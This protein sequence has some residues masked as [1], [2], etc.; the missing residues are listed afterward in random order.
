MT[1]GPGGFSILDLSRGD[2]NV[3]KLGGHWQPDSVTIQCTVSHTCF[4]L[5]PGLTSEYDCDPALEDFRMTAMPLWE[6]LQS[7]PHTNAK[8]SKKGRHFN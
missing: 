2:L 6:L 4:M 1:L 3:P 7:D 5:D 8:T